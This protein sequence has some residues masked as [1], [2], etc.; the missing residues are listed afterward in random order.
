[1]YCANLSTYLF[2]FDERLVYSLDACNV[3]NSLKRLV[4]TLLCTLTNSG[5]P[6]LLEAL[7][8]LVMST[9]RFKSSSYDDYRCLTFKVSRPT[10]VCFFMMSV[11]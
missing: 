1:M 4:V 3:P 9:R 2:D 11:D 8:P 7:R 10:P 5:A 6:A